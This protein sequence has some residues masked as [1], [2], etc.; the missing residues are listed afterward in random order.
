[1]GGFLEPREFNWRVGGIDPLFPLAFLLSSV[2]FA[3]VQYF[4]N[5]AIA[6]SSI[7][8]RIAFKSQSLIL[9]RKIIFLDLQVRPFV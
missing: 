8:V 5:E 6:I 7:I 9:G 4:T 3:T 2:F 1:M